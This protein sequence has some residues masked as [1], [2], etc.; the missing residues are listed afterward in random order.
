MS[1]ENNK[2]NNERYL[3]PVWI[4]DKGS[5]QVDVDR[6]LPWFVTCASYV[7]E[8]APDENEIPFLVF[9]F[10]CEAALRCQEIEEVH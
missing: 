1:S 9:L 8:H 3:P 5:F 7:E 6:M 4:D 10:G 2:K